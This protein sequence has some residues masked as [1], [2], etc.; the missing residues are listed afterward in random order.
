MCAWVFFFYSLIF[1]L[2]KNVFFSKQILIKMLVIQKL[3]C[4]CDKKKKIMKVGRTKVWPA[5]GER[6]D[7]GARYL[8]LIMCCPLQVPLSRTEIFLKSQ[9]T[10]KTLP[11]KLL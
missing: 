11:L 1:S 5:L 3:F 7:P 9:K 6:K 10:P 8:H 2:N 4:E